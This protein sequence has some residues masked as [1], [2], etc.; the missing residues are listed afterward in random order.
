MLQRDLFIKM[1]ERDL[2]IKMTETREMLDKLAVTM[3]KSSVRTVTCLWRTGILY[4]W[5][6][7][8][9]TKD[10]ARGI[11]NQLVEKITGSDPRKDEGNGQIGG[12][13]FW[14]FG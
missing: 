1:T 10:E 14:H 2:F 9:G 13:G 7:L 6:W 11:G 5:S 4:W 8:G 3:Q 12:Q